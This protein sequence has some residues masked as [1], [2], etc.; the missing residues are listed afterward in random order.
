[1]A[2][3]TQVTPVAGVEN[4]TQEEKNNLLVYYYSDPNGATRNLRF[5]PIYSEIPFDELPWHVHSE[6]P[7]ES[8]KNPV[9]SNDKNVWVEDIQTGKDEILQ[10]A[11]DKIEALDKSKG[12]LDSTIK[13]LQAQQEAGTA[14][15]LALTK[16]IKALS[17]GQASTNKVMASMQQIL[18]KVSAQL[19]ADNKTVDKSTEPTKPEATTATEPEKPANN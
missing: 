16:S 10:Q 4:A 12:E 3:E 8:L 2:D 11:Q 6:K 17:D 9:W 5:H 1:M 14:Q 7:D 19:D 13:S 15:S 18:L